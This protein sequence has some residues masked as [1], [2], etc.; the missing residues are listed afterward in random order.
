MFWV[1]RNA[2]RRNVHLLQR[3][4]VNPTYP[5][6]RKSRKGNPEWKNGFVILRAR[7][8]MM[9]S[10]FGPPPPLP[11]QNGQISI[12]QYLTTVVTMFT[13]MAIGSSIVYNMMNNTQKHK[14]EDN[15]RQDNQ[16]DIV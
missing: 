3:T 9:S 15:G 10:S 13:S 14:E 2:T 8:A 6:T 5:P 4:F 1:R 16:G 7:A 11:Q 12:G